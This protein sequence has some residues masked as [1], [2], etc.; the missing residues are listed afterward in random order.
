[1]FSS[2]ISRALAQDPFVAPMFGGVFPSDKLPSKVEYP[3]AYVANT[4]PSAEK[5]EHW[6]CFFFGNDNSIVHYFDSFGFPPLNC[7][8]QKFSKINAKKCIFNDIQLQG[9]TSD[10]CGHYCIAILANR[11]R[12]E[13][14][15]NIV[16]R[17]KGEKPGEYDYTIAN[18]VNELYK[19]KSRLTHQSSVQTGSGCELSEQC[20]CCKNGWSRYCK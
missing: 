6:V 16:N 10:V 4:D 7:E 5:G 11:A 17:Y 20:N 1:M 9:T 15:Y 19:I 14:Y 13:P 8:L 12:G 3:S 2:Q 18:Q